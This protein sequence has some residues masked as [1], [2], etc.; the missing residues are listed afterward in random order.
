MG[1]PW[2]L[3][4]MLSGAL[5]ASS[6][7]AVAGCAA[8]SGS[9]SMLVLYAA[10]ALPY[11]AMALPAATRSMLSWRLLALWKLKLARGRAVATMTL[12]T[13]FH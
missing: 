1:N 8:A 3:Q 4:R 11:A 2:P 12:D 10:M 6:A 7:L 9:R 13:A 5:C